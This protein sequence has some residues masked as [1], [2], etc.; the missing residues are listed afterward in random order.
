MDS[1]ESADKWQLRE[2]VFGGNNAGV[3]FRLF[4]D[5]IINGAN[6]TVGGD[7][8]VDNKANSLGT[9][10]S[11]IAETKFYEMGDTITQEARVRKISALVEQGTFQISYRLDRGTH[12]TDW[13][14][15][16]DFKTT[17][18]ERKLKEDFNTGY[19]IAFR[20]TSKDAN[21]ISTLNGIILKERETLD[22]TKNDIRR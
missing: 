9:A 22:K 8:V 13:I 10:I 2:A 12:I 17:I 4:N 21:L 16:G 3:L 20:I 6:A 19:R 5:Q 14:S 11:T 15:L 7:I 1:F 18:T